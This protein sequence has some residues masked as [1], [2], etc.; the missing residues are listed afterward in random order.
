MRDDSEWKQQALTRCL[1]QK[2]L[3]PQQQEAVRTVEGP[4]V[5]LAGAGSGKTTTIV[6]RIAFMLRFG[7]A[8]YGETPPI[9]GEDLDTLRQIAQGNIPT[10]ERRLAEILGFAPI[11]GWRIL[12][13]TFTN[14]AA[15]EMK[16]RL[17]SMLGED[18]GDVWAATFHSACV[19]ILRQHIDRLGYRSDFTIYDADDSLRV[20]KECLSD[21]AFREH[22]RV[23]S[24]LFSPKSVAAE[25]SR[26]KDRLL[27]PQMLLDEAGGD[28]KTTTI[29]RIYAL[30]QQRLFSSNALD[31]DDIIALTVQLFKAC[32]DVLEKYQNRCRYLLVDEYQDTNPAQYELIHLLA[33]KH[34]NLCV[35]GDDD[36]SIYKFRGA[37][38]ENI[39]SFERQFPECKVI[40]LEQNY[41]STGNILSAANDVIHNNV[42][43][44]EKSLWTAGDAG[45]K[46]G[47]FQGLDQN[48]EG[49]F[50]AE[51]IEQEVAAGGSYHDYA[52][53]YRNHAL[54]GALERQ[55]TLAGIPY[56]VF[57]GLRFFERKEIRDIIA[58]L[59]VI[60]NPY[61]VLRFTRIINEPKRGIGAQTVSNI[62]AIAADLKLSPLEVLQTADAYPILRSRAAVLSKASAMFD[63]LREAEQTLPL[64][65]LYDLVLEKTGYLE[66]LQT[67][68]EEGEARIENVK[69]LKSTILSYMNAAMDTGEEPSLHEFLEE[70]SLYTDQD[71]ADDSADAVTMMT[72]HSAKGLEFEKVFIAGFEENIFPSRRSLEIENGLEEER[73]LAYVALTR[74][75]KKI[76]LT[77][78][79]YRMLYGSTNASKVSR[80]L[81]EIR[82]ELIEKV[83]SG[84]KLAQMPQKSRSGSAARK[85]LASQVGEPYRS[86]RKP[87]ENAAQ[88][89][90]QV[91]DTIRHSVFG[92]GTVVGVEDLA[93]IPMLEIIFDKVGTKKI[94]AKTARKVIS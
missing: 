47:W 79:A 42:G 61:D 8:Y 76:W 35:V 23:L 36:Q 28:Y 91:G 34:H 92:T 21:P 3:N 70:V 86:E 24:D 13:I 72:I 12:A 64:D 54:S 49:R 69:E 51:T 55:L 37:T 1:T 93:G 18:A 78:A 14:K 82:P 57:G 10:D 90:F 75:K 71:R 16:S 33:D 62:V 77:T 84:D 38:I 27:T 50:I 45:E 87:F 56:R 29:A 5:V 59:C 60:N 46:I 94:V 52:I 67:Q 65:E 88:T 81:R 4:V 58:Y 89:K 22:G 66:M 73:R 53:L 39:L 11:A 80:F 32:P 40:R 19:R 43:R 68:V 9:S 30:Y 41:R 48:D 20:V 74:A 83:S 31:F 25:I 44:K 17:E 85:S 26:A 15:Q 63:A 6:S 2:G 7:D